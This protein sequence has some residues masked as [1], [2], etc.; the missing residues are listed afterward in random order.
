MVSRTPEETQEA[1]VTT[2][3]ILASLRREPCVDYPLRVLIQAVE[4]QRAE[5]VATLHDP[6]GRRSTKADA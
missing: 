2:E 1:L 3:R 6:R 4:E 5:L